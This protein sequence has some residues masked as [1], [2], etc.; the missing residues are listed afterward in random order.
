[1]LWAFPFALSSKKAKRR[2]IHYIFCS[3]PPQKDAVSISNVLFFELESFRVANGILFGILPAYSL[4][5]TFLKIFRSG[6]QDV[7]V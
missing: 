1:M 7:K 2:A 6:S 3:V 5:I 4:L